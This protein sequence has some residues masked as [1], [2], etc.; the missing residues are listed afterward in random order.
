MN[1]VTFRLYL[2]LFLNTPCLAMAQASWHPDPYLD[3]EN[4]QVLPV[5]GKVYVLIGKGGNITLQAGDAGAVLVDTQY[6]DGVDE[7]GV[8]RIREAAPAERV[9]KQ[10]G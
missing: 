9:A 1:S 2:F 8:Y 5:Q 6:G 4:L 7:V 3:T 10:A